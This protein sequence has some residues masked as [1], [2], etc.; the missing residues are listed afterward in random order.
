MH[1]PLSSLEYEIL[2]CEA[3][4][5]VKNRLSKAYEISPKLIRLDFGKLSL[6]VGV[7]KYFYITQNPP[8]A[9][10][11]PSS[12][13]MHLRKAIGGKFLDSFERHGNDRIFTLTFS[14][15]LKLILE[16]F[17]Q[18]NIILA[19]PDMKILR[20]Y[21][22]KIG[23]KIYKPAQAY[24]FP[25]NS[26]LSA[27]A[28]RPPSP[29]YFA[30]SDE[31]SPVPLLAKGDAKEFYSYSGAIEHLLNSRQ[32][33]GSKGQTCALQIKLEKRLKAQNDAILGFDKEIAKLS[34]VAKNMEG[35]LGQID[36][37]ILSA[38]AE[39]KKKIKLEI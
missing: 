10:G 2:L 31:I 26:G 5:L 4:A 20:P 29:P 24:I 1:R 32:G 16:Q 19:S 22:F 21:T 25:E 34:S 37:K 27:N 6:V 36:M 8:A 30:Y 39:G 18:G 28:S 13:A 3:Q 23:N 15:G 38:R 9:P 17:A 12:F 35:Q 7:G 14:N 11:N 33:A